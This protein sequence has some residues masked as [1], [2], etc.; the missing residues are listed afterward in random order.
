MTA[1]R[2]PAKPPAKRPAR[3][4]GSGPLTIGEVLRLPATVD[5]TT[6]GRALGFGRSKAYALARSGA[7]PCRIIRAGGTYRVPTSVILEALGID[8]AS[9]IGGPRQATGG[10]DV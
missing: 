9:L 1:E 7:F 5:V 8:L 3:W 6:A 4:N 2:S 10:S